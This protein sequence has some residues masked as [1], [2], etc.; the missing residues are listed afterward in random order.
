MK[1]LYTGKTKD[2]LLDEEK[3]I[4][5]IYDHPQKDGL[6]IRTKYKVLN[7]KNGISLLEVELL[8]GRTHQ[9]RAHLSAL[10]HPLVGDGKY[11]KNA[12]DRKKGYVHQ[13]LCSYRLRFDFTT[14]AGVLQYL[15]GKEYSLNS[16]WFAEEYL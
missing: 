4:V 2:V 3:N 1:T 16:V 15:N 13:A 6:S 11:G 14:D 10:G 5:K 8:T 12:A 9:I 7:T